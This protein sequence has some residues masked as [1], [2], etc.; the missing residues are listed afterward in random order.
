MDLSFPQEISA[1]LILYKN[2]VFHSVFVW[3]VTMDKN[4]SVPTKKVAYA[5]CFYVRSH[6]SPDSIGFVAATCCFC[7]SKRIDSGSNP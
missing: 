1:N 7:R 4:C 2:D 5:L 3:C 6:F